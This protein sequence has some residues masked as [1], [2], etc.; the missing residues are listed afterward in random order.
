MQSLV[1]PAL[2]GWPWFALSA[3]EVAA[4]AATAAEVAASDHSAEQNQCLHQIYS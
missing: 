2:L 1:I 4:A 3:A